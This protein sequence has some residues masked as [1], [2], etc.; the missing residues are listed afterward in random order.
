MAQ[1]ETTRAAPDQPLWLTLCLHFVPNAGVTAF[2]LLTVP[3]AARSGLPRELALLIGFTV[4]GIPIQLAIINAVS[5]RTG[6]S[7]V[8]YREPLPAWQYVVAVVALVGVVGALLL[9]PLGGISE[10][11]A[12]TLDFLPVAM[13][14][15][16]D[17]A[18]AGLARRAVLAT[19]GLQVLIDG[20]VNPIIEER[21]FRGFLLA[22]L[23]RLGW[24]APVLNTALFA[25]AHFWQLYNIATIF[26]LV[27]PLTAFTFWKRNYYPQAVLHCLGNTVGAVIALVGFLG[28]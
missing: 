7:V 16:P 26:I 5:R 23:E 21:Y 25:L 13:R 20:L 4:V 11:L 14:P 18:L 24:I 28:S 8:R 17:D 19:L 2:Y 6:R 9:L 22:Q 27:L 3:M 12:R 10:R 15:Q 1:T